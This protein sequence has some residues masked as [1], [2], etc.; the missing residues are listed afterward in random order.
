M[1]KNLSLYFNLHPWV[2]RACNEEHQL[3]EPSFHHY[4]LLSH[5]YVPLWGEECEDERLWPPPCQRSPSSGETDSINVNPDPAGQ[6]QWQADTQHI[7]E[8]WWK[9]R[10]IRLMA[11]R[12]LSKRN[13]MELNLLGHASDGEEEALQGHRTAYLGQ[14]TGCSCSRQGQKS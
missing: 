1:W 7:V 10:L 4:Y 14:V 11:L 12:R 5:Y 3:Y 2:P 13:A 8:F 6:V 9:E